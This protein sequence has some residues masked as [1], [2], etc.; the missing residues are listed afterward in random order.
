MNCVFVIHNT[1]TSLILMTLEHHLP[2]NQQTCA[3]S[4]DESTAP[5]LMRQLYWTVQ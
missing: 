3:C 4:P 1:D 5:S 2:A